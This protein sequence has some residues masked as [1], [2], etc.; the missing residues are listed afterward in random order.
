MGYHGVNDG[1]PLTL[2]GK[3]M[4]N[5]QNGYHGDVEQA[6]QCERDLSLTPSSTR[7][8]PSRSVGPVSLLLQELS[9]VPHRPSPVGIGVPQRQALTEGQDLSV[10]G[11]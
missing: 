5:P 1:L 10:A 4:I 8:R 7:P 6:W 9:E 11:H 2:Q 3:M